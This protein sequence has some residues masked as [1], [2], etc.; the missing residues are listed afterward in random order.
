MANVSIE[1][2]KQLRE[3]TSAGMA[4]CKNAL[5]EAGGDM[6]KAVEII[7][8]KGLA[9]SAKR[10]GKIATEGQVRAEVTDGGRG[11][12]IV[13]VNVETDFSARNDKF[14]GLVDKA[15][16]AVKAAPAGGELDK[17]VYEGKTLAEHASE[18][19]AIIGEKIT[20][21]RY[22]KLAV[23]TGKHGLCEA[24]VHLGGKIGVI[25]ALEGDEAAVKHEAT[26]AHAEEVVLQ[27]CAMNPVSLKREDIDAAVIAK[28]K[29]I[30]EAQL[31]EDPKMASRAQAWP[32]IIEGKLNAWYAESVLLEQI[33]PN[34]DHEKKTIAQLSE[35]ASKKAGGTIAITAFVR[36]ELGEGIEKKTDD[37]AAGVA[38]LIEKK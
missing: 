37:L 29:E 11:A 32:K 4:D 10:S 21:R 8:K 9:K 16:A 28:Q 18:V 2:I 27:I 17:L 1:H 13:E 23:A 35:D 22:T 6:D 7:L 31:R 19:T 15:T 30:F 25:L 5:V 36:Y 33:S 14:L 3:R 34:P 26:R 12:Y 20:L 38:E 24:Y